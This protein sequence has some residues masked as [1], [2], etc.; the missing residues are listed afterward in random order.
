V[1]CALPVR[2]HADDFLV[3]RFKD[4]TE[5]FA[6]KQ[7]DIKSGKLDDTSSQLQLRIGSSTM[8][9][10]GEF[11]VVATNIAGMATCSSTVVVKSK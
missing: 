2:V 10:S 9:D 7:T 11:K 5:L 1:F 6:D 8:S 4:E 3:S